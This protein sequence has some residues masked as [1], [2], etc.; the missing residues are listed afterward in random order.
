M[1]NT[2]DSYVNIIKRANKE[3][4]AL[5]VGMPKE[6]YYAPQGVLFN[7]SPLTTF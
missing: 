4:V 7:T 2:E 3:V 6:W 1:R 5:K